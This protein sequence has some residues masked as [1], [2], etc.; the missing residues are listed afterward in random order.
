MGKAMVGCTIVLRKQLASALV[1]AQSFKRFHSDSVFSILVLDGPVDS[2]PEMEGVEL[3]GLEE[4]DLEPGDAHLLPMLHS[5]AELLEFTRPAL[6]RTVRRSDAELA[7]Y[8]SPEIEIFS[9]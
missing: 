7:I 9:P 3:L 8:F 6:L 1:L 2:D 5:A 4:I